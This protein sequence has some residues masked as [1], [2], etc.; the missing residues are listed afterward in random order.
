MRA[1]RSA[2]ITVLLVEDSLDAREILVSLLVMNG[3]QVVGAAT[4]AEA[5]AAGHEHETIHLL[6]TDLNL[7]DGSGGEVA[8]ALQRIH[9][10]MR[11]LF[12]SGAAAP[13]LGAGQAFL[14]KPVSIAAVLREIDGLLRS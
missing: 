13:P 3:M 12:I 11:S 5:L 9:P 6:L 7:P 14:Q 1:D 4:A 10:A 2:G 8:A